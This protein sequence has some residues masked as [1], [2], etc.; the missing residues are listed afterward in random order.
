MLTRFEFCL[1]TNGKVVPSGHEWLHEIKYDG[2]RL[3][4]EREGV[5]VRLITKGG[6]DWTKRYPRVVDVARKNRQS[7]FISGQYKNLV[8]FGDD[9]RGAEKGPRRLYRQQAG[10]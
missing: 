2:Y 10:D 8:H 4:L 7:R 1:P 6:Y 9:R 3:R 5:R